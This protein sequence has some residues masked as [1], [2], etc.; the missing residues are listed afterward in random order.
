V[1][2]FHLTG[3]A[4][5]D[6]AIV[7]CDP[8]GLFADIDARWKTIDFATASMD[9]ACEFASGTTAGFGYLEIVSTVIWSGMIFRC[10][11]VT[12]PVRSTVA[13]PFPP[14]EFVHLKGSPLR[15]MNF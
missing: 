15:G 9:S 10:C 13:F 4:Q 6:M 3:T 1:P 11:T 2:Y 5:V 12:S 14:A 8:C 7:L